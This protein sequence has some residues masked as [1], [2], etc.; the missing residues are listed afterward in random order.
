MSLPHVTAT[1]G[2]SYPLPAPAT[3]VRS[4]NTPLSAPHVTEVVDL[5]D[6]V[7]VVVGV[8][9]VIVFFDDFAG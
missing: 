5:F 4:G 8:T 6:T 1:F 7:V 2:N 9:R 3:L